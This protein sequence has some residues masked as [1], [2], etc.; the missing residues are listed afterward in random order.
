[1]EIDKEFINDIYN[2]EKQQSLLFFIG[3]GV[4]ISQGY[5][6][7]NKYVDELIQFWKVNLINITN[8][9]RTF[10]P[11]VYRNDYIILDILLKSKLSNKRKVDL[12]NHMIKKYSKAINSKES[13]KIYNQY[14]LSFEKFF[15]QDMPP[16]NPDNG[17]LRE[18]TKLKANFITTNYDENI[19]QNL[20]SQEEKNIN[21]SNNYSEIPSNLI[22]PSVI[23]I[24]GTP[25]SN[26]EYF[27]SSASSYNFMYL[28]ENS[29]IDLMRTLFKKEKSYT[30]VFIGCSLEEE[31]I[32]NLLSKKVKNIKLYALMK[33]DDN[34]DF[35]Q[36]IRDYY[37][38]KYD[39]NIIWYGKNYN[40]LPLFL[41]EFVNEIQQKKNLYSYEKVYEA[42]ITED[43]ENRTIIN[44]VI[45]NGDYSKLN[46]SIKEVLSAN[47]EIQ[48]KAINNLMKLKPFPVDDLKITDELGDRIIKKLQKNNLSL[49]IK[50]YEELILDPG[51]NTIVSLWEK[52]NL[53]FGKRISNKLISLPFVQ[54]IVIHRIEENNIENEELIKKLVINIDREYLFYDIKVK[55]F[56]DKYSKEYNLENKLK[57]CSESHFKNEIIFTEAFW[58]EDKPFYPI[59]LAGF[60]YHE[61]EEKLLEATKQKPYF[62]G[63]N[64]FNLEGQNIEL[65]NSFKNSKCSSNEK[66]E[67]FNKLIKNKELSKSYFKAIYKIVVFGL[68]QKIFTLK[69]IDTFIEVN[70][71]KVRIIV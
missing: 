19:E 2:A 62:N 28:E 49:E 54:K 64:H 3:A 20:K 6:D 43:D 14:V 30:M 47:T 18:I 35:N 9:E 45:D 37:S 1:M 53:S 40:E 66:K 29:Y 48:K 63:K 17:I 70:I 67:F 56:I 7:W 38:K 21:I 60:K 71:D 13:D 57:N 31:E 5:P 42:L 10:Y 4:S 39:I 51:I 8:D 55:N 23:H 11:K 69:D 33:R 65:F 41:E 58:I 26:P 32:M 27:I 34:E 61:I 16:L 68:T 52:N 22:Y 59:D 24:H 36:F 15:F 50:S 46:K 25:N 12:V 44:N